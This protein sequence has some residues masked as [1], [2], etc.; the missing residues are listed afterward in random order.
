MS[1]RFPS[2]RTKDQ[3]NFPKPEPINDSR[4]GADS[5]GDYPP[6]ST[7]EGTPS[8]QRFPLVDV[9]DIETIIADDV[10]A[11]SNEQPRLTRADF[12]PSA[13]LSRKLENQSA[14][15]ENTTPTETII[16]DDEF[17][18]HRRLTP[19]DFTEE[20]ILAARHNQNNPPQPLNHY[21]QFH[22]LGRINVNQEVSPRKEAVSPF[23]YGQP[24][25]SDSVHETRSTTPDEQHPTGN[26][27][28]ANATRLS[29]EDFAPYSNETSP[30]MS[31]LNFKK[32]SPA[33]TPGLLKRI[34]SKLFKKFW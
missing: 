30:T 31:P 9:A 8:I 26:L 27:I 6:E 13:I 12:E 15:P 21:D 3:E 18:K 7:Q 17:S 11:K 20:A 1:E 22:K 16:A 33:A 14:F 25:Q 10:F 28:N 32:D 5:Q 24:E 23:A 34:A 2:V 4:F 19:Y 29:R